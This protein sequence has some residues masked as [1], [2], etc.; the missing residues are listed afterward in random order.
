[1]KKNFDGWPEH[2]RSSDAGLKH[3]GDCER[4]DHWRLSKLSTTWVLWIYHKHYNHLKDKKY[5]FTLEFQ[6]YHKTHVKILKSICKVQLQD[7]GGDLWDTS[8]ILK[9]SKLQTQEISTEKYTQLDTNLH[10]MHVYDIQQ[11]KI[12]CIL[13]AFDG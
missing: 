11:H 12:H 13:N 7:I 1:M 9:G 4:G 8:L 6:S 3:L 2:L 5:I 10:A